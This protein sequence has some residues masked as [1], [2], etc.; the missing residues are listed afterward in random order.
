MAARPELI[1][2]LGNP[3]SKY[4]ATR[5]N[6]GFWFADRLATRLGAPPFRAERRFQV[7]SCEVAGAGGQRVRIVKP[8]IFMNR[9]G[10]AIGPLARYFDIAPEAI[11]VAHDELDLPPGTVRIKEGGGHGGHNGLRDLIAHLGSN[12]FVR[13]RIGIGRPDPGAGRKDVLDYVLQRPGR[14]DEAVIGDAIERVVDLSAE[15]FAGDLQRAMTA[16]HTSREDADDSSE[17]AGGGDETPTAAQG[18]ESRQTSSTTGDE[19]DARASR[20][21]PFAAALR[22]VLGRPS[23]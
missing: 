7:E 11:L 19:T 18:A 6:A 3:G 17:P 14:H 9:S 2:G 12:D 8:A 10:Q 15:L 1:V 5:H 20:E 23:A 22:A 16:L 13:V 4:E 21:G